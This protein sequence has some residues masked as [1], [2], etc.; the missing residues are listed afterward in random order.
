MVP[1]VPLKSTSCLLP[2]SFLS[3]GPSPCAIGAPSTSAHICCTLTFDKRLRRISGASPDAL[4]LGQEAGQEKYVMSWSMRHTT[5]GA[6]SGAGLGTDRAHSRCCDSCDVSCKRQADTSTRLQN[7][8]APLALHYEAQGRKLTGPVADD[9]AVVL[10]GVLLPLE[11]ILRRQHPLKRW[12]FDKLMNSSACGSLLQVTSVHSRARLAAV[13]SQSKPVNLSAVK[14]RS[15]VL[16][17]SL[18][19]SYIGQYGSSLF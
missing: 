7:L 5:G 9:A 13:S 3:K 8:G 16:L 4:G 17:R 14:R 1:S 6:L 11:L 12:S 18:L 10:R 19:I 2:T 15:E